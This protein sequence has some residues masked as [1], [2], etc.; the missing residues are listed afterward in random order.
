[1][2]NYFDAV[3]T[4]VNAGTCFVEDATGLHKETAPIKIARSI[5]VFNY[6]TSSI[7]WDQETLLIN[8]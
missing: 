1:M 2:K 6:Y 7:I 4:K 8:L 3:K 5:I